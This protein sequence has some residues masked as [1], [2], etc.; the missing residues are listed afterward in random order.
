M[1]K[2]TNGLH[3]E[4]KPFDNMRSLNNQRNNSFQINDTNN[5]KHVEKADSLMISSEAKG[6]AEEERKD[7]LRNALRGIVTGDSYSS[8]V[9]DQDTIDRQIEKLQKQ[10]QEVLNQIQKL[11]ANKS[12]EAD[13]KIKILEV[14]LMN[15]NNQLMELFIQK[16]EQLEASG[17]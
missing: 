1:E 11:R 15:L 17:S 13:E 6:L 8:T 3:L 16:L 12:E 2:I 7:S 9:N 4:I 14:K 10:I 5:S